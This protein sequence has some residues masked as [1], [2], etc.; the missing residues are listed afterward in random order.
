MIKEF[1]KNNY[2]I[3]WVLTGGEP[4]LYSDLPKMIETIKSVSPDAE[5]I[6]QTNASRTIRWWEENCHLFDSL[7]ITAH[8]EFTDIEH[9]IKVMETCL[10]SCE[11]SDHLKNYSISFNMAAHPTQPKKVRDIVQRLKEWAEEDRLRN[12]FRLMI[13]PLDM[14]RPKKGEGDYEM[15][16]YDP[17][18][19]AYIEYVNATPFQSQYSSWK[20]IDHRYWVEDADRTRRKVTGEQIVIDNPNYK[21]WLCN[22]HKEW[23]MIDKHGD[24]TIN[25]GQ[26]PYDRS[27][28]IYE[29]HSEFKSFNI[30]NKAMVCEGQGCQC[31]GLYVA[32]KINNSNYNRDID[33]PEFEI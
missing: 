13:K 7:W 20:T 30:P 31:L 22:A 8:A 21:G 18:Y 19:R 10:R 29:P 12:R 26:T 24:L 11:G 5:I 23:L 16:T 28:N 32:S 9:N 33:Y 17:V 15:F 1:T 14:G 2:T 6:C 3:R 4:T 27:Y 25:C